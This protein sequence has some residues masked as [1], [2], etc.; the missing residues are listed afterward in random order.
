MHLGSIREANC[1]LGRL[2]MIMKIMITTILSG[3]TLD[4]ITDTSQRPKTVKKR[5]K[6]ANNGQKLPKIAK[7]GQKWPKRPKCPKMANHGT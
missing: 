6:T 5:P 3:Y 1:H 4:I 7:N 2:I